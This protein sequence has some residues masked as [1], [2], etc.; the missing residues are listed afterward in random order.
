MKKKKMH[1]IKKNYKKLNNIIRNQMKQK[2]I[3]K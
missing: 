1:I 3:N 2:I